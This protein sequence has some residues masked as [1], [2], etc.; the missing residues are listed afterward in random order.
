MSYDTEEAPE[1]PE[2]SVVEVPTSRL[3]GSLLLSGAAVA[4]VLVLLGLILVAVA[5]DTLAPAVAVVPGALGL[6]GALWSRFSGGFNFRVATSPDGLRLRHGLLEHRSQTLPPGRVQAVQLVQPLLWRRPDWW[7]AR[8]NVAGYGGAGEQDGGTASTLLPVAT[9][10]EALRVLALLVPD[11]GVEADERPLDVVLAGLYGSGSDLAFT[12]CPP[13]ARWLDPLAWRR[14]GYRASGAVLLTRAGAV[15]RTLTLVP[16]ARTQSCGLR[17]G[18]LQRRL[19]LASFALHSTPGPVSPVV[20]HLASGEAARL[21]DEQA[22]RAQAA[23]S[24]AGP[25]RWMEPG[26]APTS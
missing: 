1:A 8:V 20:N 14:T 3:V 24:A 6:A 21:L 10:A 15:R 5:L 2:H 17:Q 12:T 26:P 13:A 11:L 16:H 23:R 4:A 22:A 7:L 25:E 9:R 18:P 19:G